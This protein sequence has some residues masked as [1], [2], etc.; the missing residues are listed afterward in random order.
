MEYFDIYKIK[1][2]GQRIQDAR[3]EKSISQSNLA[4]ILGIS[5]DQM[6]NIEKGRSACKT[7]YIYQLVQILSVSSD[8]LFFGGKMTQ[9]KEGVKVQNELQIQEKI[10]LL[11]SEADEADKDKIYQMISIIVEKKP[12]SP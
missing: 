2:M 10:M 8:Y 5:K 12:F 3:S 4:K 6:S 9:D 7:D 11:V 1:S